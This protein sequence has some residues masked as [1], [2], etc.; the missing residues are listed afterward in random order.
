MKKPILKLGLSFLTITSLLLSACGSA[1]SEQEEIT[2][3]PPAKKIE[4]FTVGTDSTSLSF[5]KSGQI[6]SGTTA[7]VMPQT[8]GTITNIHI[9]IGDKVNKGELL[10]TLGDS[11]ATDAAGINYQSAL[12]GLE[13]LDDLRF[14]TDYSAQK[15][16]QAVMIGYYSAMDGVENAIK[17]RSN[18]EELY[19]EQHDQLE[20][21]VDELKKLPNYKD[22]PIYKQTK[23]QLEQLEIGHEAQEDQ[24]GF[25]IEM[26]KKQLGSAI[27]AVESVQ[28]KYS[29]QFIQLDSSILQAET[30]AE[31]AALQAEARNIRSP[32]NGT[33]TNIQAVEGNMAS[34][35]QV[36]VTVEDIEELKVKTYL[37]VE[38]K[39]LVKIGDITAVSTS[40]ITTTGRVTR[41]NPTLSF[42]GKIE[43]EIALSDKKNIFSGEVV[44]ITFTPNTHNI[45]TLI[46]IN[47][48][49][50]EDNVYFINTV[51]PDKTIQRKVVSTG[52]VIGNYIEITAGL[53]SGDKVALGSSVFLREGDQI[54][55]KTKR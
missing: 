54:A 12:E 32:I 30:G 26:A 21:A 40:A 47:S 43:M 46:P 19:D 53:S 1:E 2:Q 44:D 15:D 29:L 13:K 42:N 27:L 23:S 18:A 45:A 37:S 11:L 3:G 35:G 17:T 33:V 7:F 39:D 34:P 4:I 22:D 52:R 51:S 55:Y 14:K 20:D 48:V 49:I 28:S 25:A 38:E 5:Q 41:I 24:L 36:L 9:S 50:I 6:E 16:I 8:S 10:L 31:L